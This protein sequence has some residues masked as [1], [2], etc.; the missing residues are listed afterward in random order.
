MI[1][2]AIL[3]ECILSCVF[4]LDFDLTYKEQL[5]SVAGSFFFRIGNYIF[6]AVNMEGQSLS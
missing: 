4:D 6:T 5:E 2:S 1:L 3:C